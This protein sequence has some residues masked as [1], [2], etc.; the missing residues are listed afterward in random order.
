[1]PG[2]G[3]ERV[4]GRGWATVDLDRAERDLA[5][6][7]ADAASFADA[8]R[9]ALL[10]ATCRIGSGRADDAA[11]GTWVVILEPDAEGRL[12]AFLARHGE[13]WAVT[14]LA[15]DEAAAHR[16]GTPGPLGP[17]RLADVTP[18]AG[19]FRMRLTAATI[20]R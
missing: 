9:S 4:V 20:E 10:G 8:P 6:W 18:V 1:M 14:W 7:L 15:P 17:E 2:A 16:G 11:G 19:P 5:S 12:A 3:D 13:G